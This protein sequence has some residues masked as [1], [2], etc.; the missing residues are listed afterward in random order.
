MTELIENP[1][2]ADLEH[3]H[4][5]WVE[6]VLENGDLDERLIGEWNKYKQSFYR[7]AARKIFGQRK[8]IE[9]ERVNRAWKIE[10]PDWEGADDD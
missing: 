2:K 8:F 5:Y 10:P 1:E 7:F 3:G 4:Y 9:L 6:S